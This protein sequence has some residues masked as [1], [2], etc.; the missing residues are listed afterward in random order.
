M[1][2]ETPN[3]HHIP[4]EELRARMDEL[5]RDK[6]IIVFCIL[7]T[8]GYEAQ[9]ILEQNGFTNVHFIKGGIMFWPFEKYLNK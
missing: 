9:L 4:I 5:P 1:P 3:Y 2:F 7:C 8:R 6:E